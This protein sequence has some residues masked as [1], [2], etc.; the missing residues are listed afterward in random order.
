MEHLKRSPLKHSRQIAGL[1]GVL[2]VLAPFALAQ[3]THVYREG[4]AWAQEIKGSLAG[5]KNLRVKVDMGSVLVHGGQEQGI[6]YVVHAR[7]YT[8][9]EQDARRQFDSFKVTAYVRGDT[10]WIVGDWEGGHHGKFSGEFMINVPREMTLTKLETDGGNVDAMGLSGRV[11]AESGGGSVHL[12]DIGG[13]VHAE[14]GGGAIDVGMVGGG[15][16]L[17]GAG[18]GLGALVVDQHDLEVL[19]TG[20]GAERGHTPGRHRRLIAKRDD[21]RHPW[22]AL[23]L[24]ADVVPTRSEGDVHHARCHRQA[25]CRT[26][27]GDRKLIGDLAGA[28]APCDEP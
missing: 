4:G 1:L 27:A 11:E 25:A 16:G 8:S 13:G 12:D 24:S 26:G 21:D 19:V 23:D 5:V 20:R 17:T 15:I 18:L 10:A 7:A 14:T 22:L 2:A 3:E 9:S 28:G 6:S